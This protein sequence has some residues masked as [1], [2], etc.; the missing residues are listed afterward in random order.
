VTDL[1]TKRYIDNFFYS[2]FKY[3]IFTLLLFLNSFEL[4]KI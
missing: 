1:T 2:A 4:W 3:G